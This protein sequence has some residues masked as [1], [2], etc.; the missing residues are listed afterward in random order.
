MTNSFLSCLGFFWCGGKRKKEDVFQMEI[1]SKKTMPIHSPLHPCLMRARRLGR[2]LHPHHCPGAWL[3]HL[4]LPGLLSQDLSK[5]HSFHPGHDLFWC[6]DVQLSGLSWWPITC[7]GEDAWRH[8]SSRAAWGTVN[9]VLDAPCSYTAVKAPWNE[10]AL[11][12]WEKK[13]TECLSWVISFITWH[14]VLRE[15]TS[16]DF[17]RSCLP[18]GEVRATPG[19]AKFNTLREAE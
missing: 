8:N 7:R 13:L 15:M 5:T 2:V 11:S 16:S 1:T 10:Q 19:P 12:K 6:P 3:Q 9:E 18:S 4:P 17:S 14:Q